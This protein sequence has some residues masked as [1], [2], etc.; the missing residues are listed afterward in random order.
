MIYGLTLGLAA[1]F[2]WKV[3]F[4]PFKPVPASW[5]CLY[6]TKFALENKSHLAV[7][8]AALNSPIHQY[9]NFVSQVVASQQWSVLISLLHS[10]HGCRVDT[11]EEARV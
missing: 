1:G 2:V 3:L 8:H 9:A 6:K 5:M 4:L 7:I 11:I 10:V